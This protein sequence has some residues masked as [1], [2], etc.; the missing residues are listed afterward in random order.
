VNIFNLPKT[1]VAEEM[2]STREKKTDN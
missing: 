1:L 2:Q